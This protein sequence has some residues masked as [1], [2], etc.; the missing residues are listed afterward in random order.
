MTRANGD[1]FREG[2]LSRGGTG[3]AAELYRRFRGRDPDVEPLL[4]ARG[5]NIEAGDR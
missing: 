1:A 3:D 4:L 5:L 2:I